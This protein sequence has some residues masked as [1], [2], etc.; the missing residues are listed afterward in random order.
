MA[1]A[2]FIM[3]RVMKKIGLHGR[4][5]IPMIIGFGCSIPAIMGTRI[6]DDRKSRFTTI[7]V[8]PL[9][10][11]GARLPI[12]ALIIPAFFAPQWHG[13]MMWLIY[14][15]GILLAI[16]L[17]Y[18]LRKT[19]LKGDSG[20]FLMELPPYRMPTLRG[21]VIHMWERS[22]LYLKKAGTVILAIS[23]VLWSMTSYPKVS[24]EKLSGLSEK[25]SLQVELQ[26]SIAGKVGKAMEPVIK[27]MGFDYRIGTALIGAL[28]AKEVFVAQMGIVYALG[29]DEELR[30]D[31]S[32]LTPLQKKLQ[33]DYSSLQG[34][35][36]MLFCLISAPCVATLAI[37]RRE[38]NSWKWALFQFGGLTAIAYIITVVVY[39]VGSLVIG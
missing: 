4:S 1:R 33:A 29:E 34:F 22:W 35:C 8:L 24:K 13:L 28:A 25:Q 5:F 6:L 12:Y 17:S 23:I 2:A 38:T 16:L 39:Q 30:G 32:E 9:M 7:M 37:C 27:P 20:L 31:S 11:C 21:L 19:F 26:N 36:I 18:I 3:D 10:S 14:M 15:I